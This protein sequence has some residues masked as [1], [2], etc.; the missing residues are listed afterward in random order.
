MWM[1]EKKVQAKDG[2]S[3]EHEAPFNA[4]IIKHAR[5][6][7]EN[8]KVVHTT[9]FKK[10]KTYMEDIVCDVYGKTRHFAMNY[11]NRNA[12]RRVSKGRIILSIGL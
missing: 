12:T 4:N 7:K 10:T 6:K 3:K 8:P 11:N 1:W 2:A 5:K 9:N